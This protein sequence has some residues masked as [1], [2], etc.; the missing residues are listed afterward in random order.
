MRADSN[1]V[2][3]WE[4]SRLLANVLGAMGNRLNLTKVLD[5]AKFISNYEI[6]TNQQRE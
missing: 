1:P 3:N 2:V 5:L 4:L 6:L